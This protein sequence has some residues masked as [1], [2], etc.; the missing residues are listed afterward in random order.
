MYHVLVI[1]D[2]SA[3][4][5]VIR[6][7]LERANARID[8]AQ[9]GQKALEIARRARPDLILCDLDMPVM[10]GFETLTHLRDD[11]LLRTVPVIMVSGMMTAETE[12]KVI[13]LGAN[14]VLKKP[15]SLAALSELAKS[16]LETKPDKLS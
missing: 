2:D 11:P 8:E 12:R 9:D 10:D 16:L 1:D 3:V 15:F 6:F 4:R 5:S 13:G 14:A 7:V